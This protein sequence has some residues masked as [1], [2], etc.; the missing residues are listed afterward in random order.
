M[1]LDRDAVRQAS[2][3]EDIIPALLGEP[4]HQNGREPR[5]RCPFHDDEHTSIQ[6]AHNTRVFFR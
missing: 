2:R 1:K 4:L 6:C 3:L 5:V